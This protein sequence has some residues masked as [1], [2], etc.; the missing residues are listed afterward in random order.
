MEIY[1]TDDLTLIGNDI[2]RIFKSHDNI[3]HLIDIDTLK[4]GERIRLETLVVHTLN[5]DYV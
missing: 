3:L 5:Y 2:I 1:K 4:Y